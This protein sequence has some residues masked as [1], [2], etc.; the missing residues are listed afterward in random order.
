MV[1]I[2][3]LL[4]WNVYDRDGL[5]LLSKGHVVENEHQLD[6]LLL[7]GAFVD[8]TAVRVVERESVTPE[9]PKRPMAPPNLFALWDQTTE[10]LK[11]LLHNYEGQPDGLSAVRLEFK[12]NHPA[13]LINSA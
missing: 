5:L 9:P 8:A 4:P 6:Q 2:G 7:R 10:D 13:D 11:T 12:Q 1:K 3:A